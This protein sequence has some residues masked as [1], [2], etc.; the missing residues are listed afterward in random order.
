MIEALG[1]A[2][3]TLPPSAMREEL[4]RFVAD[5]L[6]LPPT[7]VARPGCRRPATRPARPPPVRKRPGRAA[8]AIPRRRPVTAISDARRA[9]VPGAVHRAARTR[10][11]RALA[12]VDD[13]TFST[14]L[15]R[16]AAAHLREHLA[17]PGRGPAARGRESWRALIAQ[18]AWGPE[19]SRVARGAGGRALKLEL[20]RV[21]RQLA[22]GGDVDITA[23]AEQREEL[24]RAMNRAIDRVMEQSAPAE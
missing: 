12:Q 3:A 22:T 5:R 20:A 10:A 4:V 7:L 17:T 21:E 23:L 2:F 19:P 15:L 9:R 11:P 16:R 6:D 13:A 18:L 1:P 24:R 14:E 8:A